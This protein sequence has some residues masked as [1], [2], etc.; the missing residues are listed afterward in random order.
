LG[1]KSSFL[2]KTSSC[3]GGEYSVIAGVIFTEKAFTLKTGTFPGVY[4]L[5]SSLSLSGSVPSR[6]AGGRRL[7][8]RQGP[9]VAKGLRPAGQVQE[10]LG[11]LLLTKKAT[12]SLSHLEK[13]CELEIHP[14]PRGWKRCFIIALAGLK[15]YVRKPQTQ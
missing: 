9:E 8:K 4:H 3:S 10:D 12:E 1:G 5:D 13:I 7:K 2:V 15:I 6:S 14:Q 11:T